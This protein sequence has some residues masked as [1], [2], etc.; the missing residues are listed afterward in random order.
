MSVV[1]MDSVTMSG[2][3]IFISKNRSVTTNYAEAEKFSNMK[4]AMNF[5]G[6]SL[7]KT[8]RKYKFF[9]IPTETLNL[10]T[11][12]DKDI[13]LLK[14]VLGSSNYSKIKIPK[15]TTKN[16]H[17]T[18]FTKTLDGDNFVEE[19][20]SNIKTDNIEDDE[21][22]INWEPIQKYICSVT[23][24]YS[25][26]GAKQYIEELNSCINLFKSFFAK[27]TIE[28]EEKRILMSE[29]DKKLASL[30]HLLEFYG[31][32]MNACEHYKVSDEIKQI[33]KKRR[34][35]K[36]EIA[37]AKKI[38]ECFNM[39]SMIKSVGEEY[40]SLKKQY[41]NAEYYQDWFEAKANKKSI[42]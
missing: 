4:K 9:A 2:K 39:H 26:E 37:M 41:Y 5:L 32:K 28:M 42:V 15:I 11:L 19:K 6:G 17:F 33:V 13:E 8:L 35:L 36:N 14:N 29:C 23:S 7:P 12:A 31:E 34:R 21:G 22:D 3:K 38:K 25:I 1:L 30:D 24:D 27:L 40:E 20:I 18:E 10:G 16:E